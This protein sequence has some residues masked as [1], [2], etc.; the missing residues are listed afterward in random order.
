[1][2]F[3][4]KWNNLSFITTVFISE[5]IIRTVVRHRIQVWF[6]TDDCLTTFSW[7]IERTSG[8]GVPWAGAFGLNTQ[9]LQEG[10]ELDVTDEAE[11]GEVMWWQILCPGETLSW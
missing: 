7:N 2:E 5:E 6:R 1:M 9:S 8:P 11:G 4:L 3:S 10:G